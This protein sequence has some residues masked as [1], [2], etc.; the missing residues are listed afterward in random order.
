MEFVHHQ[1]SIADVSSRTLA[2][3]GRQV[4]LFGTCLLLFASGGCSGPYVGA[5]RGP[6]EKPDS[7]IASKTRTDGQESP[8]ASRRNVHV[9]EQV[10]FAANS[11]VSKDSPAPA[12]VVEPTWVQDAV[13]YQ[14][15]PERFCN[16]DTSNDP[17]RESLESP[18]NVPKDWKISPWT[19][20]WY[21]R[22]DWEKERGPNFYENGVFDR[23]YGGDLQGVL[24]KLDYL[25]NLGIN[26]IYFNPVFY[27]KSLHKYDGASFHHIDPY[28]GPDPAGDLK[29]IASETS[30]PTSWQWTAADKL[31]LEL[32]KQAHARGLRVIIDGVF[33][34]TGRDFFAFADLRKRQSESP[35]RDWY[36]VQSFDDPSTPQNEF[37]YK[38][39]WGT[40][41][42]PEFAN[43]AQGDDLYAGP[44]KY[45]LDCTKRWMDPNGTATPPMVSMVGGWMSPT[46]S[47]PAFGAIGTH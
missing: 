23:R 29:I 10:H 38:G 30:D 12:S 5:N 19:G 21:A 4:A 17:T 3:V 1:L 16:G 46:R 37:R 24:N 7:K 43:N 33:N 42:L 26:T 45:I 32:L 34:H 35:Y 36:I 47:R 44:K 27:A 6:N 8:L 18:D 13:F 9:D 39:W 2:S 25:S 40:D 41:T 20:D 14:I 11:V 28:F 15:F 22:A 31:F